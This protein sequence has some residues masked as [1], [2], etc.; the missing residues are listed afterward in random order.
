MGLPIITCE[1][2]QLVIALEAL[3]QKEPAKIA[4]LHDVWKQGVPTPNSVVLNPLH[5]DERYDQRARGNRVSRTVPP[6]KLAEWIRQRSAELGLPLTAEEAMSIT[7][8]KIPYQ[9]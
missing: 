9:S 1:F 7:A 6:L 4:S 2:W 5:F 3:H 8:G